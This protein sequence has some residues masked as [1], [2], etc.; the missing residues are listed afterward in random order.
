MENEVK[1]MPKPAKRLKNQLKI[2]DEDKEREIRCLKR[3]IGFGF[4]HPSSKSLQ[5]FSTFQKSDFL[6]LK[7]RKRKKI[8]EI[9]LTPSGGHKEPKSRF[10]MSSR[11]YFSKNKLGIEVM[12]YRGRTQLNRFFSNILLKRV[13]TITSDATYNTS[14]TSSYSEKIDLGDFAKKINFLFKTRLRFEIRYLG[15]QSATILTY[16]FRTHHFYRLETPK[17]ANPENDHFG[18]LRDVI[19]DKTLRKRLKYII[20]HKRNTVIAF[21]ELKTDRNKFELYALKFQKNQVS[22]TAKCLLE[23][24]TTADSKPVYPVINIEAS[25][26]VELICVECRQDLLIYDIEEESGAFELV[27]AYKKKREWTSSVV[28]RRENIYVYRSSPGVVS[29]HER[30]WME[31]RKCQYFLEK[32]QTEGETGP[33]NKR[34]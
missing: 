23:T 1:G 8:F 11:F 20:L 28:L 13:L 14:G 2:S 19:G 30:A 21:R 15:N 10:P 32:F 5:S 25:E 27:Y 34:L 22:L 16:N 31:N 7:S 17:I 12:S 29:I 9:N 24:P 4:I 18:A 6:V 3:A 33:Q 26:R